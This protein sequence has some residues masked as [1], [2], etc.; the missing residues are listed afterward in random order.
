[1]VRQS[2][3]ISISDHDHCIRDPFHPKLIS[4]FLNIN[5]P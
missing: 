4:L 1:V 5:S 2:H 3:V